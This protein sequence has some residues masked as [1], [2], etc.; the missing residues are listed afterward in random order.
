MPI[1]GEGASTDKLL[2]DEQMRRFV[3]DG[4]LALNAN[5]PA[6]VHLSI[7]DRLQWVLHHESN[8]GNNVLPAVPEMQIVLDSPVVRGALTSVLGR[9]WVLHPH[10]FVH[11]NEPGGEIT[12][13]GAKTGKGSASF[14]GWHQDS[15]SPLSRPRHHLPRYAMILYY[16]QD[17]PDEMGPTQLIPATH[18]YRSHTAAD[19]ERGKQFS[20]PAGACI[21][22]HFDIVHGGSFNSS[23]TTR[24]MAKFVFVRVEEP[25]GTTWDCRQP[26]WRAPER[27]EAPADSSVVWR[28]QWDWLSGRAPEAAAPADHTA[29]P[30]L[31]AAMEG[32]DPARQNAIYALAAMGAAA[33]GPLAADLARRTRNGWNEDAVVMESSAYALAAVG[34]PAVPALID[35][36]DSESEWVQIN[37]LFALGEIGSAAAPAYQHVLHKL[38]H[39]ENSVVRT[40]LDALGQIGHVTEQTLPEFRRLLL[41]DNSAWQT[42]I[43][44][45][46][47]GQDQ[48]RT[49]AMMA[50]L[51]LNPCS[52]EW[53]DLVVAALPDACGYVGGFGVEVLR[54][55]NTPRALNGALDYLCAHRWDNTL[56]KGVRTF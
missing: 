19:R 35:M 46:W 50:L 36:L 17:T 15:H 28:R 43:R 51:R 27:F 45:G 34:A 11:N 10:R 16:P 29:I 18:L 9:N 48:V 31:I 32:D 14:V 23:E 47:T 39:P 22:V 56:K 41:T 26:Q 37:A 24:H 44:R 3:T 49:N 20:G 4:Y 53:T 55:Q 7:Y 54:R 13:E 25:T 33:V 8:P 2:T 1:A 38:R 52:D 42:P 30:D 40:A 12:A 5:V 6:A 21:L